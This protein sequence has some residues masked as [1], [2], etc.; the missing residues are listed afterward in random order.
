MSADP[1]QEYFC[2]G[3]AEELIDA[4]AQLEGLRVVARTSAFRFRGDAPDLREVGKKLNVKTVL[5]G[6]VR[7]AGNRLRIN[8]QLINTEDGYHLWS[9]RYD[10][11]MEDVFAV[12]DE[13]A[14]TVVEKLK[15][16]LLGEQDVPVVKR[17]TDNLEAY[18]L[19]LKG[20]YYCARVTGTALQK[21]FEC[22][23]QALAVEPAYAQAQAGIAVIHT[24]RAVL[25]FA[26]PQ[27]VM[28][29]AKEAALKAL[30][31]D[32]TVADAHFALAFVLAAY[33][34]NWARAEQ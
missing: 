3:L 14:R 9:E 34:W 22:F 4:L 16:K 1:E 23:T 10:R 6:S 27:Q 11:D 33:E 32:E 8:A 31:I 25:S 18:K 21:G 5:E 29:L 19:V 15:V 24:F 17:P 7:K 13:I 20:R 2:D 30:A 28:P 12:Q 26:V